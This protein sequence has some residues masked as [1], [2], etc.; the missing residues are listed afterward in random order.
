MQDDSSNE[1]KVLVS[2]WMGTGWAQQGIGCLGALAL[3]A[4]VVVGANLVMRDL[5]PE[6]EGTTP[7]FGAAAAA[8]GLLTLWAYRRSRKRVELRRTA[9]GLVLRVAGAI[10]AREPMQ[11]L[12]GYQKQKLHRGP[13]LTV[14]IAG[15]VV[16]GR[17]VASFTEQWGVIHGTPDWPDQWAT[18]PSTPETIHL[19]VLGMGRVLTELVRQIEVGSDEPRRA[20]SD[21]PPER[22]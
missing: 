9:E 13:P 8:F 11:V 22:A 18:L 10:V 15:V 2:T 3:I 21:V 4:L 7:Y 20:G 19:N 5:P 16:D 1:G 6:I 17:C 14:L 12:Y